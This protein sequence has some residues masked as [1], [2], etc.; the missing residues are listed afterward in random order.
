[1]LTEIT[2][3]IR[4]T[5]TYVGLGQEGVY[6]STWMRDLP[7]QA[8]KAPSMN[9]ATVV[10]RSLLSCLTAPIYSLQRGNRLRAF[11][12]NNTYH[13]VL[14]NIALNHSISAARRSLG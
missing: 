2:K 8:W 10:Y 7:P 3:R 12:T 4:P 1:M 13:T 11:G 5:R 14:N 9:V 6:S